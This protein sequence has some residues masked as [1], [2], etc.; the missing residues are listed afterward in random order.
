MAKNINI[1]GQYLELLAKSKEFQALFSTDAVLDELERERDN[2]GDELL[3]LTTML[4]GAF[5]LNS[6]IISPVTPATLSIFWLLRSP[7]LGLSKT[8][9]DIDVDIAIYLMSGGK[10]SFNGDISAIVKDS[11]GYCTAN[12]IDILEA[13]IAV[14]D[15]V[16]LAFRAYQMFPQSQ[17]IGGEKTEKSNP[18][19]DADWLAKLIS[20][21][22]SVTG[23]LPAVIMWQMSMTAAAYYVVQYCRKNG[24]KNIERRPDSETVKMIWERTN[25]LAEN[26]LESIGIDKKD[27]AS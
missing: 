10:E 7:F 4:G 21:V 22:H 24:M 11:A 1:R 12:D 5:K 27:Y 13:R 20:M 23:E 14:Y 16:R 2:A 15:A 6:L 9:S 3:E 18:R 17:N 26:Y 19:F 8:V 25:E